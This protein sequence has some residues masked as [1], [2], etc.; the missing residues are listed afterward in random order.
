MNATTTIIFNDN[1]TAIFEHESVKRAREFAKWY[2]SVGAKGAY[3][4]KANG[5]VV[6]L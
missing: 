2:I 4:E 3:I 1:S 5:E 6:D